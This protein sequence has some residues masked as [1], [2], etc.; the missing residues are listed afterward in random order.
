VARA[1][2]LINVGVVGLGYFGSHHA[3]H[4]AAHP[5]ARLVVVADADPER[6]CTAAEKFGAI[7]ASDHRALIGK[8]EAA[9]IAVPTSEHHAVARDL[10][11]AGIH[12]FIEKPIA[13]DASAAA[14]LV[15]R[16]A[17]KGLILQVGHIERYS[18]AFRALEAKVRAPRL[19]ECVRHTPWTG[20]A[21][22]VDVVL[23]L[24]I[25]DIDLALTL[26][27]APVTSV[28][29][30]GVRVAT[31]RYDAASARLTFANGVVATLAA[32]RVASAGAR[33]LTVTEAGRQLTSDLAAQT[34]AVTTGVQGSA[35]TDRITFDPADN[36]AAEIDAFLASV[37]TGTSPRVDGKA[38]LDAM[39]VA[40]MIL[41]A[42]SKGGAV[43]PARMDGVPA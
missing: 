31:D 20:R 24:M 6:A 12:V 34:L 22:D 35:Q 5:G 9:S 38:G 2:G 15:T 26:A 42:I 19:I 36:L 11:E 14:D 8:V 23:D 39:K 33:M 32:S 29:A 43:A 40:D 1:T 25:H 10:I 18:P 13:A 16:A 30:A 27:G 41:A 37:S 4:F 28:A 21:I 3:R 7:A 17:R